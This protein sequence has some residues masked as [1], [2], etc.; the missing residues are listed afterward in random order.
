MMEDKEGRQHMTTPAANDFR[1]RAWA[2]LAVETSKDLKK[3]IPDYIYR[4]AGQDAPHDI[5]KRKFS[6]GKR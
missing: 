3:N 5:T 2:R 6:L 1:R 4:A